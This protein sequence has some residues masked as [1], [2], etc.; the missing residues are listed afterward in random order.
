M[1]RP[2]GVN[3]VREG[4]VG[5]IEHGEDIVGIV[6]QLPSHGQQPF[7]RRREDVGTAA[8]DLIQVTA[9]A[10]QR[11]NILIKLFQLLVR[12]GQDLIG[13]KGGGGVELGHEVGQLGAHLLGL[14]GTGVLVRPPEGIDRQTLED[15]AHLISQL[16][17]VVEQLCAL[18]QATL[19]AL[20]IVQIILVPLK[21]FLPF[22]I[23]AIQ[24]GQRPGIG[25]IHIFAF[26]NRH[27]SS[28]LFDIG[29]IIA[30]RGGEIT[31]EVALLN[32]IQT[33]LR[34]PFR[35]NPRAGWHNCPSLYSY[36]NRPSTC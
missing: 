16:Q 7:L 25:E 22:G 23:A 27:H 20:D 12:D 9:I 21:I 24:V 10:L 19:V 4:Q 35:E 17:P 28:S 29:S 3:G 8:A 2:L 18:P 13:L 1:R 30:L 36:P 14:G 6:R 5:V 34:P 15:T 33:A 31:I 32:G 26:G 11:R